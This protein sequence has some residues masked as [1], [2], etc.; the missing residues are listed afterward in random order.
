M[1][2]KIDKGTIV[3]DVEYAIFDPSSAPPAARILRGGRLWRGAR[4]NPGGGAAGLRIS[5][6]RTQADNA[7]SAGKVVM[8]VP[9][10]PVRLIPQFTEQQPQTQGSA[11]GIAAV[12]ADQLPS[13]SQGENVTVAI[14]D[15][16]IDAQHSAFKGLITEKNYKDFTGS[17]LTD[18]V[19]HGT[20]C[21]GIIFGRPVNG[22]RIGVAPGIK[23]VLIGKIADRDFPTTTKV[24]REALVWAVDS[25]AQVI[26]LSVGLDFLGHQKALAGG[27][28]PD[29]VATA[30]ALNDYRDYTRFFDA[31]MQQVVMPGAAAKSALLIAA[32]GNDSVPGDQMRVPATLPAVADNVIAVSALDQAAAGAL[33][34]APFCNSLANLCAPGVGILSASPGQ[35][36]GLATMSGTSQAAPHVAA[37]AALWWQNLA[38][39][40]GEQP[41]PSAV[42]DEMMAAARRDR[43]VGDVDI[44][45]IGRGLA[46]AP[47]PPPEKGRSPY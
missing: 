28:V 9:S 2:Q 7:R 33:T 45:N 15:T 1:T 20:H 23:N 13:G 17:D 19:G 5:T 38:N 47:P 6:D 12:G 43:I 39:R 4:A 8:R 14:L 42:R 36:D 27:G 40:T 30:K 44:E 46:V 31:L 35:S 41:R 10:I 25:G 11:W 16:G 32:C 21:A 26:S 24:L 3:T 34:V 22:V 29:R 37:V 18:N